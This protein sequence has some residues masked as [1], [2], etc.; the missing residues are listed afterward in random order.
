[1]GGPPWWWA[2]PCAESEPES[3]ELC[4]PHDE[5]EEEEGSITEMERP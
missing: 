3:S 5:A 4:W 1:M 2:P